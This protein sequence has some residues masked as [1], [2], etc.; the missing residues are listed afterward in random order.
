[1]NATALFASRDKSLAFVEVAPAGRS[2]AL[3]RNIGDFFTIPSGTVIPDSLTVRHTGRNA[4]HNAEH[5]QIAVATGRMT[6]PA[7]E[8]ALDNFARNAAARA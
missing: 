2:A 4:A 5:C 7:H 6:V 1:M 8:T 3:A